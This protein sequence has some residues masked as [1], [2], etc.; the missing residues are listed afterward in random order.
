M[1][2]FLACVLMLVSLTACASGASDKGSCSK[3]GEVCIKVRAEEP[4]QFGA[5]VTVTITLTSEKDITDLGVSLMTYPKSIVVQEAV[6]QEPGKVTW[7]N[8]S[9][10][11]WLVNIKGN[12][13]VTFTRQLKLSPEDGVINI[14]AHAITPGFR[15][16]DTIII[17]LTN[18]G[19]KVYLSG[20]SIPVTPGPLPTITPG[21]SP[22]FVPTA[23]VPTPFPSPAPTRTA[24]PYPPPGAY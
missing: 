1:K 7:K 14:T 9:G 3:D 11:D 6:D 24:T 22:T 10:V 20:T 16:A 15:A 5:P 17:Y 4:I 23:T 21:P 2:R 8:Q 12:Q 13:P 18:E 19:G